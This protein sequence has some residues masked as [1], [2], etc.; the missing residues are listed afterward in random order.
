MSQ[1]GMPEGC[2]DCPLLYNCPYNYELEKCKKKREEP[3][4]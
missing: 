2:R 4:R 1:V 3:K